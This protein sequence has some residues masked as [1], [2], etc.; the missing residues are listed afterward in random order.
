MNSTTTICRTS[1]ERLAKIDQ[2]TGGGMQ[3]TL[4]DD[5]SYILPLKYPMFSL[6]R[7]NMRHIRAFTK[8]EDV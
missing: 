3:P 6:A 8:R 5:R 4:L 7:E 2:E 1:Y